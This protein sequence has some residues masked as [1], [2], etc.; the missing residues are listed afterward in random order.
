VEKLNMR[1]HVQTANSSRALTVPTGFAWLKSLDANEQAE[2]ISG[3]LRRV[4][5]AIK[6][7]D[8]LP[9]AEWVDEWKATANV[10]ADPKVVRGIKRGQAELADGD[11]LDWATLRKD[12]GL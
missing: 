10:N 5:S 9:V 2:F 6:A 1:S 8:W 12:L 4:V 7:D 3:L 11:S